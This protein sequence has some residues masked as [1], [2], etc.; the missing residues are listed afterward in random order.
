MAWLLLVTS[1]ASSSF[2]IYWKIH[3]FFTENGKPAILLTFSTIFATKRVAMPVCDSY[4]EENA[5]C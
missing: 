5:R 2:L 1:Y 3:R 4:R